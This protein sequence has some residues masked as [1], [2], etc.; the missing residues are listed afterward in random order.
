[1]KT[2][3]ENQDLLEAPPEIFQQAVDQ[4]WSQELL[5]YAFN[6][7]QCRLSNR[8]KLNPHGEKI[9]EIYKNNNELSDFIRMWR[10]HFLE[11][12][13][14]KFLPKGWRVDHKM[15]RHFGENSIF[16]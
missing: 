10:V 5:D 3:S 6:L 4:S 11:N 13:E 8:D 14:T 16:A 12:N 2:L 7:Q 9:V 1:M 15:E